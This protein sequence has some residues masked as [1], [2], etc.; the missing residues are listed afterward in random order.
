MCCWPGQV[1]K[2]GRCFGT[3][4]C[5]R[6]M[7]AQAGTCAVPGP[8]GTSWLPVPGGSFGM[9]S[10]DEGDEDEKPVHE[11]RVSSFEMMLTEVT[12][13]M[14]RACVDKGRCSDSGLLDATWEGEVK[15]RWSKYCNWRA[16]DRK[17]HPINCVNWHQAMGFCRAIGARLPTEA[18]WEIAA[19]GA[20][21]RRYAWG[22]QPPASAGGLVGNFADQAA[23]RVFPSWTTVPGYDDGHVA[24][25]PA[26]SFPAGATPEGLLDLSGNVWEWV[27]DWYD[28][29]YYSKSPTVDPKGP[30]RGESRTIRGGSWVGGASDIRAADRV[31]H[32]PSNRDNGVGFRCVRPASST[33]R[34]E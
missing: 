34:K 13:A 11:V 10:K 8:M 21:G 7:K 26:A 2:E 20:Q 31:G 29:G 18:E 14:Y 6:G 27:A 24:T 15:P 22:S 16:P 1:W 28:K 32:H 19:R 30:D 33:S 9:G 25:A 23:H 12:V 4:R 17:Q 3:P 5:P